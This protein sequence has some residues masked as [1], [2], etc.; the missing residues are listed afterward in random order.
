[1][2]EKELSTLQKNTGAPVTVL[3]GVA[4][5]KEAQVAPVQGAKE[6]GKLRVR[7]RRH[8]DESSW[9]YTWLA[10]GEFEV[11]KQRPPLFALA[12]QPPTPPARQLQR[13]LSESGVERGPGWSFSEAEC[14]AA[15]A[16]TGGCLD[17]AYC[18]LIDGLHA[19]DA[20]PKPTEPR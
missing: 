13:L 14:A 16:A 18:K 17:A 9:L 6:K 3:V 12:S 19:N 2:K 1:M 4:A 11:R 15:L 8:P 10:P 5:G 20:R 7:Y